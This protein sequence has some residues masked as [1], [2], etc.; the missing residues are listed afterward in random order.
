M[1]DALLN[2]VFTGGRLDDPAPDGIS[3]RA[4]L[5]RS[6]VSGYVNGTRFFANNPPPEAA[7]E[8]WIRSGVAGFAPD[9]AAHFFL[10]ERYTDAFDNLTRLEF[11]GRYDSSSV[12]PRCAGQQGHRDR[13]RL[14]RAG[15]RESWIP[16]ATPARSR[17]TFSA[18]PSRRP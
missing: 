13:V 1:T 14:P 3:I 15:P 7:A 2:A 9:A 10:P 18:C 8:Y 11:D 17:S 16:A 4:K 5:R 6:I 12:E